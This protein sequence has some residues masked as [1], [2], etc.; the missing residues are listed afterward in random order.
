MEPGSDREGRAAIPGPGSPPEEEILGEL[1]PPGSFLPPADRGKL[2]PVWP[3]L[4]FRETI[5]GLL[6][7]VLLIAAS[8]VFDAPLEDPADPTRTPNPAKAPW[9]FVGLQ[10]L[11]VYFDPWVAG[12]AIPLVIIL[13]L[14]AI[15]YLD[16]TREHGG[17]YALRR[18]PLASSLFLF[19]LVAWFGLIAIGMWFRG[20]G[21]SWVWPG[22]TVV[23]A[24]P[25]AAV[26][27][28][29]NGVGIPLVLAWFAGG[30]AW[31]VRRTRRWPRFTPARRW[32]FALLALAMAGTAL[33]I[34]LR[35]ALGISHVVSFPGT[36][37]NL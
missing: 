35:L 24:E 36:G 9:Y 22:E 10:E 19:G 17:V 14:S 6:F 12:V 3:N 11:L 31:I 16:P 21:W 20:P 1:A 25:T 30:G 7:V 37:F 33:K 34:V 4:L 2:V 15:P 5:A 28:L 23:P 13:G 32:G 8:L 27:A 29:P 26:R 18:R